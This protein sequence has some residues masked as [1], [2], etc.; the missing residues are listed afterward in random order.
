MA[1]DDTVN[2]S[3]PNVLV[4]VPIPRSFPDTSK[5]EAF[6]GKNFRR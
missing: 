3:S 2:S 6:D 4:T 5:I 1:S